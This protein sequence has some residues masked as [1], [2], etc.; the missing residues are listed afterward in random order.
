MLGKVGAYRR[1]MSIL[2]YQQDNPVGQSNAT[3]GVNLP[4]AE[5]HMPDMIE[6]VASSDVK[7]MIRS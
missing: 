4:G 5:K 6:A 1:W 2:S 3:G 7:T